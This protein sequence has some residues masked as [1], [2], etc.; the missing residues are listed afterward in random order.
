MQFEPGQAVKLFA[1]KRIEGTS[2][3]L[4]QP[5]YGPY[6]VVDSKLD[7]RVYY[8]KDKEG[9]MLPNAVSVTRID[10]WYDRDSLRTS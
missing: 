6:Y 3:K 9:Q 5:F 10:K 7:G 2:A 1:P 4:S 8:L